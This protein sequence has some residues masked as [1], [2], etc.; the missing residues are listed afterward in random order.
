[1]SVRDSLFVPVGEPIEKTSNR[2]TVVGTGAVGMATV[3]SLLMQGITN[4]VV[5]IDVMEDKLKGEL[6]D[7]QHGALFLKNPKI[8]ASKDYADSAGSKVCIITAGARQQEGESR[9]DLVQRNTDILKHIVPPLVQYSPDTILMIVSN[10][11]DILTYVAWKLSGLPVNRV[12][13]S[14]TNLDTSRFRFLIS[15]R[16]G[17]SSSSVHGWIIGEHGDTSVPVWSGVN[18]AG[19]RL[20]DIQPKMGTDDDPEGWKKL[21]ADVINAAYEIIK[22]KG[23]TNWAIGLSAAS[24]TNTILK[25]LHNVHA[26]SVLVQ[27]HHGITEE[28]YLSLPAILGDTGVVSIVKQTLNPDEQA[29]LQKSAKTM[30]A[31]QADLKL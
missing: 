14:G 6:M 19:V 27:G 30:A 18:V 1:M 7:L 29:S 20:K 24:L 9:L 28:V 13:G 22:L 10:P 31:V 15:Q 4:D 17:C 26:V 2:V 11:C 16:L 25:N 5:L 3:V 12:F 8:G 23:Y 21:H